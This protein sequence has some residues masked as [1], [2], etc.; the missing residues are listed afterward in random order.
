MYVR[1]PSPSWQSTHP[2]ENF[3]RM[4]ESR[5]EMFPA[6]LL[7]M[8]FHLLVDTRSNR[9]LLTFLQVLSLHRSQLRALISAS[10]VCKRWRDL[11]IHDGTLWAHIPIEPLRPGCHEATECF[12]ERSRQ[13][14]L[15][16][17]V[18]LDGSN[19]G[20]SPAALTTMA[21]LGAQ[22]ARIRSLCL[23]TDSPVTLFCG[24]DQATAMETLEIFNRGKFYSPVVKLCGTFPSLRSL[25]LHGFSSWPSGLFAELTHLRL[26]SVSAKNTFKL[27]RLIDLL[28]ASPDLETV[29]LSSYLSVFDDLSPIDVV[30]LR[31]LQSFLLQMCDSATILSHVLIPGVSVL[32]I[33]MNHRRLE[34]INPSLSHQTNIASSLPSGLSNTGFPNEAA[35]LILGQ[36]LFQG[37]FRLSLSSMDSATSSL[38]ITDCSPATKGFVQRSLDAIASHPYFGIVRSVTLTLSPSIPVYWPGFLGQFV[39]LVELN[40]SVCRGPSVLTTLTC[41]RADG[42]PL[43]PSLK[44]VKLLE[45]SARHTA[46]SHYRLLQL[47]SKFRVA[48]RCEP[49]EVTIYDGDGQRYHSFV[50]RSRV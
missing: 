29:H 16:V 6:E 46:S 38:S 33:I 10:H 8:V 41:L 3:S 7:G 28:R 36:G 4:S 30:H 19:G 34:A 25:T 43:C 37:G 48:F 1:F 24:P 27:S 35:R 42:T 21:A 47:L 9:N 45:T 39:H 49:V 50:C 23:S 12:L 11:V 13:A 2:A 18:L 40:T 31:S 26:K 14:Q 15:D 44:R 5:V 20:P 22:Y 17:S 32:T